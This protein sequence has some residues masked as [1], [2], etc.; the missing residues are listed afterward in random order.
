M[1]TTDINMKSLLKTAFFATIFVL[2]SACSS[3]TTTTSLP[4]DLSGTPFTGTLQPNAFNARSVQITF[5]HNTEDGT[6]SGIFIINNFDG[7]LE[8]GTVDG[9]TSGNN[10]SFTIEDNSDATITFEGTAT[11]NSISGNFVVSGADT[12]DCIDSGN[13]SG[14]LSLNR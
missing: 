12:T 7:C 9:S 13:F 6:F 8:G 2:V 10:I 5:N 3:G 1:Q 11:N 14:S 4:P